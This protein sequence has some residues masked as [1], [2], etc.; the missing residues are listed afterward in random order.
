VTVGTQYHGKRPRRAMGDTSGAGSATPPAN[1]SIYRHIDALYERMLELFRANTP[2]DD[3]IHTHPVGA[4]EEAAKDIIGDNDDRWSTLK[5][6][7]ILEEAFRLVESGESDSPASNHAWG[8]YVEGEDD[9]PITTYHALV[10][11]LFKPAMREM[12]NSRNPELVDEAARK[13][14]EWERR[15][16]LPRS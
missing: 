16:R 1:P 12:V 8:I 10:A 3:F 14:V 2:D 6:L 15:Q 11:A 5:F 13:N 9:T 7:T 4:L